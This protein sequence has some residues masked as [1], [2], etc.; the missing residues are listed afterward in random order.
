MSS[1]ELHLITEFEWDLAKS[2]ACLARRG[3]DFAYAAHAFAD[4]GLLITLDDRWDYGEERYRVLAAIEG[5]VFCVVCTVR[6]Q[7]LRIVSA[8]KAN[9]REVAH[10]ENSSRQR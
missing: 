6:S 10:Y 3:F 5:R 1:I 2:E 7:A 4:P 8:R 9:R